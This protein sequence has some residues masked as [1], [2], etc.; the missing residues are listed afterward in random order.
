M[1]ETD[2]SHISVGALAEVI[3]QS[4]LNALDRRVNVREFIASNHAVIVNPMIRFGGRI[5]LA[6]D[7]ALKGLQLN[8]MAE[9]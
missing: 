5:I 8:E 3:S 7:G 6:K 1:P 4:V 9:G 2:L